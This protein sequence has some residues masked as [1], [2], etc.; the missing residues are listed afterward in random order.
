MN[1][2][3]TR[4]YILLG[5][6]FVG[7][8]VAAFVFPFQKSS[9]FWIAYCFGL[10]SI[11]VQGYIIPHAF[12]QGSSVKSK[13][14]GFPIARVGAVYLAVQLPLSLVFMVLAKS[15]SGWVRRIEIVLCVLLFGAAAAGIL[16]T[17]AIR[18]EVER[19]DTALKKDVTRMRALQSRAFSL[20]DQCEDQAAKKSLEKLAEALRY[21]DPVSSE[22]TVAL[23]NDL[24]SYTD[25]LQN[26][27]TEGDYTN[28]SILCMK[29]MPVLA[30]RNQ[31]CKSSK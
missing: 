29:A 13:F 10:L 6:V 8:S 18:E 4:F 22:A 24:T 27:L 1:R 12:R 16:S 30:Q 2:N 17:D 25:E 11:G 26:A 19:Q 9:I 7:F 28:V 14:Y 23:E 20:R 5:I 21:S 31:L 3:M 15:E